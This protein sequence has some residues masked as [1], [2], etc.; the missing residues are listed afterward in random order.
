MTPDLD[1]LLE[2]IKQAR[3]Q[4]G[5]NAWWGDVLKRAHRA[6]GDLRE[7]SA[8]NESGC[9]RALTSLETCAAV[10]KALT[11]EIGDTR[12]ALKTA[13][14]HLDHM[15]AWITAQKAGY[16]F[17]GLSEDMPGIRRAAGDGPK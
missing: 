2:D 15:A 8:I 12:T 3:Q 9:D 17:E 7:M 4:P 1:Q 11:S 16:S 5:M 14:T 10:C 6:I 13:I